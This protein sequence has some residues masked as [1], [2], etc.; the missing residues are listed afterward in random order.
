MIQRQVTVKKFLLSI[1]LTVAAVTTATASVFGSIFN[2]STLRIDFTVAGNAENYLVALK[3]MEKS[4][5]WWGR[6]VNLATLPVQGNAQAVMRDADS[7]DTLFITSFSTLFQEWI[8]T[9]EAAVLN[10]AMDG[11]LLMPLPKKAADIEVTFLS[12][13]HEP[14]AIAHFRYT[15]SDRNVRV[16]ETEAPE[17]EYLWKGGDSKDCIDVVFLGEGYDAGQM[18]TLRTH[19]LAAVESIFGH[20]PF[21]NHRNHF[22]FIL[23]PTPSVDSGLSVPQ[24]GKWK[25]TAF[26]SHYNT[27]YSP[28]YLTTTHTDKIHDVLRGVPYEHIII[29]ANDD[30]YGGGGIYNFYSLT[31]ARNP[32]F[33]PVVVHE[34]GH[35]FGSL[36]DEYFYP[37]E[38]D[39]T[40]PTDIE[41]W[42]KN[43]TTLVDFG[44]KWENMFE[45]PVT[46]D[47]INKPLTPDGV[48]IW[49][50]GG[51]KTHGI[52][53]PVDVACRMHVNDAEAFCPVC[54]SIIEK[55]ISYHLKEEQP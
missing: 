39:D 15:P 1:I 21:S 42:E 18:D 23:V 26:A 25:D 32:L 52:Y 45:N 35:S 48:G 37:G 19:A 30:V 33:S 31:T 8:N 20:E 6:R 11:T 36:G 49:E 2:D 27:F 12:N 17:Y 50:G 54:I 44:S 47:S 16:I 13:R 9:P 43:I 29:L 51:Y 4:Q 7:N 38:E 10:R 24:D 22:N 3:G 34:F 55:I 5:H 41:P 14:Q 53:R 40:Y 28:R 46:A